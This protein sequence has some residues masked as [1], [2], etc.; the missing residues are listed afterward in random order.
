MTEKSEADKTRGD[1]KEQPVLAPGL[2]QTNTVKETI[3]T[4]APRVFFQTVVQ[5]GIGK[6]VIT[7]L[8]VTAESS[9]KVKG[10]FD[11]VAQTV[12]EAARLQGGVKG[13][14]QT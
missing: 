1:G 8:D 13:V 3:H 12:N 11:D 14:K 6:G 7:T 5:T 2:Q 9:E 4:Q 10:L